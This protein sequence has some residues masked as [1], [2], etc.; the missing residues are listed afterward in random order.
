MIVAGLMS[1]SRLEEAA[2]VLL[3]DPQTYPPPWNQLD[4][5]A[6]AYSKR[7]DTEQVIRYYKLSLERNLGNEWARRKLAELGAGPQ[8]P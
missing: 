1:D 5:L 7:G 4:A 2:S 3:H 6:R 8:V